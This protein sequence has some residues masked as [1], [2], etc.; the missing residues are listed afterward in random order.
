MRDE[1]VIT[2]AD[3][4]G[5]VVTMD[6]KDYVEEYERQLNNTGNYNRLQK[7]PTATNNELVHRVIKR[8]ETVKLFR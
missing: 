3:K 7:G 6:V 1:I 5:T 4:G 8:L 2:N